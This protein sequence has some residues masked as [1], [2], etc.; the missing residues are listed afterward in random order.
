MDLKTGIYENLDID[1]SS[2]YTYFFPD[3]V[4]SINSRKNKL[5]NFNFNSYFQGKKFE[6]N[7]KQL[8]IKNNILLTG[9]KRIFKNTVIG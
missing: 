5:F 3:G 2:K 1:D 4:F 8:K 6:K 9:Q 7:Q